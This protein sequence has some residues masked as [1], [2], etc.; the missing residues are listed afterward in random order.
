MT[1]THPEAVV[2]IKYTLD[3]TNPLNTTSTVYTYT[4]PLTLSESATVCAVAT[5]K[6]VTS[7]IATKTF[8]KIS[9]T[10]PLTI[11]ELALLK[12]SIDNATVSLVNAQVVY[13]ETTEGKHSYILREDG[14]ALDILNSSLALTQGKTYAGNL[15]LKVTYIDGILTA[16]DIEGETN[17]DN[18]TSTGEESAEPLPIACDITQA[19]NFLGDLVT[20]SNVQLVLDATSGDRFNYYSWYDYTDYNVYISNAADFGLKNSRYYTATLW[21]MV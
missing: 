11:A 17:A 2:T 14:K 5:Y 16:S 18:L 19:K 7:D 13:T 4:K 8:T 3:G 15:K 20:L 6:N 1:I 10:D 9:L 12:T 21:L